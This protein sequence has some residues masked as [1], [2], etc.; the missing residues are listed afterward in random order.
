MLNESVMSQNFDTPS[1]QSR[2]ISN[3]SINSKLKQKTDQETK[4]KKIEKPKQKSGFKSFLGFVLKNFGILFVVIFYVVGG[5]FLFKILEQHTE[6]QNCQSGEGEWN[7]L[8]IQYR[9]KI[10]NYIHFNTTPNPWLPVDNATIEAG[11]F[12]EKD[13]PPVYQPLLTNWVVD[14]RKKIFNISREYG[15]AGQDCEKQSSWTFFSSL[16]FTITIMSTLGY[17]H[18][19]VILKFFKLFF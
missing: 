18:V 15:Y 8:R 10:F 2:P 3:Y 17:G 12:V 14:F 13:G 6:I 5:A 9:S 11:L 1:D 19:A 7:K 16:L 4:I